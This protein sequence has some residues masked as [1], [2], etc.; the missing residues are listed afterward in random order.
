[1]V[2]E[3][4]GQ[5][6]LICCDVFGNEG[7]DYSGGFEDQADQNGNFSAAPLFCDRARR[8]FT[9][10][11]NSPCLPPNNEC[12]VLVGALGSDCAPVPTLDSSWGAIKARFG[13]ER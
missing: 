10:A 9:L 2:L 7:G 4:G 12:G 13:G 6:T 1:M 5:A 8:V 3:K 11:E